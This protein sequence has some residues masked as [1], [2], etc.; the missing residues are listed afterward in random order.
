VNKTLWPNETRH[1]TVNYS[2][3]GETRDIQRAAGKKEFIVA[4]LITN[5]EHNGHASNYWTDPVT[6]P[7]PESCP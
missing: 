7:L 3:L 4:F 5:L 1:I 6:I 2:L